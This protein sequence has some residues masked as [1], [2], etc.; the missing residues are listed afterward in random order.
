MTKLAAIEKKVG[1]RIGIAAV[2]TG[3]GKRVGRRAD[4]R[5]PMCSTFKLSLAAAVLRR[6]DDG[7][8]KLD[9]PVSYGESDLL[10][11]AP[12]TA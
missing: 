2:D 12:V 3:T 8:E 9:R 5:F 4:E 10:S 7:K 11:Y 1:G 6:V